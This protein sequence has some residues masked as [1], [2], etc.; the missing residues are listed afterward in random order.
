MTQSE[1]TI[2]HRRQGRIARIT[3]NRPR[4]L[5]ALTP[6]MIMALSAALAG[7]QD[8][9]AVHAVVVEGAGRAFCAGGDVR[10]VR[11][12][13]LAGQHDLV[14]QFFEAEYA[15]NLAIA[16]YPKPYVALVG[17]T[18]MGGGIGLSVHGSARVASDHAV[19]AMPEA[20]IGLFADVGAT[21]A[22]PRLRGASG[23]WM[24]LTGA[25]VSGADA[26]F[27][28]LATHYVPSEALPLLADALAVNG[29]AALVDHAVPPPPG[30]AAFAMDQMQCF[31]APSVPAIL[32]RLKAL[33]TPW[34]QEALQQ[35]AA[36]S[37]AAILRTFSALRDGEGYR[38]EQALEAELVLT[39]TATRHP[40]FAEGVRAMLVDKD[41]SPRWADAPL[42]PA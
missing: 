7:Y 39:R 40:D 17:G 5:N 36:A 16:R 24:A 21:Y 42:V 37:P 32:S 19:F 23:M 18:C 20:A 9:P 1:P 29:V 15:L 22:L 11:D 27:L 30:P 31:A 6:D 14:E 28:G 38:L 12:A 41:R 25:R 34:A 10:A 2:L 4:A 26:V 35:I 8:D 13:V 3:L 33:G